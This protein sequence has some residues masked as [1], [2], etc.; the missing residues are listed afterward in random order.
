MLAVGLAALALAMFVPP[1]IFWITYFAGT[2]FASSWGPVAFMSVWSRRITEAGAFWGIVA[3]FAGN[4]VPK[5][6]ALLQRDRAAG[7]G[8]S[9]HPRRAARRR[10]T[11][12]VSRCGTVSPKRNG[13]YRETLHEV[14]PEELD[15][16]GNPTHPPLARGAH[17]RRHLAHD[18]H[19]RLLRVAV[20]RPRPGRA[21]ASS[22]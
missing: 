9:D 20:P 16:A 8:G 3:G 14:P 19:G 5:A 15:A 18:G 6:L 7:L 4:V 1:N 21:A 22:C 17:D 11:V 2:V 13:S 12:W 10:V